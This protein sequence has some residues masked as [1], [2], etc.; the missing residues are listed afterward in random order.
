[1]TGTMGEKPELLTYKEVATLWRVDVRTVQR[2][3]M[4]GRLRPF[5]IGGAVRFARRD[6]IQARETYEHGDPNPPHDPAMG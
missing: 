4:L 6:V 2:W 5:R 1:M 3:V